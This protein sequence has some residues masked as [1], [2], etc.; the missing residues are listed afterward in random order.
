MVLVSAMRDGP[1]RSVN[2]LRI[3]PPVRHR[4]R[5]RSARAE[6][7]VSVAN[8]AAERRILELTAKQR[9][10]RNRNYA[11]TMRNVFVVPFTRNWE[12]IVIR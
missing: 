5:I 8:A 10:D 3:K 9:L 11:H 1:A 6:V 4:I 7:S 12:N 2:V